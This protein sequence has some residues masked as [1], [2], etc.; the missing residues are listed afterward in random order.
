MATPELTIDLDKIAHNAKTLKDLYSSRGINIIGVT[1]AVCGDSRLAG[2]IV[3]SGVAFLADSRIINLKRMQDDGIKARFLLLRTLLSEAESV[4]KYADVS[5]NSD[6]SV[7]RQL[8]KMAVKNTITHKIILMVELG[9]LREGIMPIDLNLMVRNIIRLKGIELIGIGTNLACFGGIRPDERKMKLLSSLAINL[10]KRFNLTL[11]LVSGGNSANYNWFNSSEDLGRIN[12]LRL[13]E[14]IFL[15][16][17]PLE[18]TPIPELFTDAFSLS[19]EVIE[20]GLKPS[21]PYG[22][23]GLDA[24]GNKPLF[25]DSGPIQRAILAIGKQDVRTEGLTHPANMTIIGSGSDH[26]ILNTRETSLKTGEMVRFGLNYGALLS[27]M[28]SNT[29]VKKYVRTSDH[30]R[31]LQN[32]REERSESQAAF[33]NG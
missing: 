8:S 11:S 12:N 24:F 28:N 23:A 31:I 20:S 1:K 6:L 16:C 4:V 33:S 25:E 3:N 7:I 10:E 14:S 17:E 19:A 26:L 15:G 5:L 22:D 21:A 2:I 27:A 30:R 9:D 18:R 29:I 32:G 13:G